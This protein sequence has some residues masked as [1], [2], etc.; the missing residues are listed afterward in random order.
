MD[1]PDSSPGPG[2]DAVAQADSLPAAGRDS[3]LDS[4]RIS[5]ALQDL[6]W[7]QC[8]G[9]LLGRGGAAMSTTLLGVDPVARLFFFEGCRTP[10]EQD[11]LLASGEVRF[12]AR[13]RDVP[14]GFPILNPRTVRYRGGLACAAEF[15]TRLEFDE[16][17]EQPRVQI[18]PE[19]NFACMLP[20]RDGRVQRLGIDNLSQTGVGL[21]SSTAQQ[22]V[23]PTGTVVERCELHFGAHGVM[24]AALQATGHGIIRRHA[25]VQHLIGCRFLALD[26]AQRT[27]LQRLVYRFETAGREA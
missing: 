11:F 3:A 15:P 21:R 12:S 10:A 8:R 20:A 5:L 25:L 23:L 4:T 6:A 7:L 27:F 1:H 26:P 19:Y 17:R 16:R 13:L 18:A 2:A 22:D 14:I 24:E 9:Q